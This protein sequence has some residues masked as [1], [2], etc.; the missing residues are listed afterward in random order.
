MHVPKIMV[1]ISAIRWTLQQGFFFSRVYIMQ[2]IK[3]CSTNLHKSRDMKK[4]MKTHDY[5]QQPINCIY[6]LDFLCKKDY[7]HHYVE[8]QHHLQNL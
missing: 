3:Q 5:L 7:A 1:H 2:H 8:Q 4:L 6:A